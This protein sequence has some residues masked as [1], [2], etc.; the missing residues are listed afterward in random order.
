MK[1]RILTFAVLAA[2]SVS[3]TG[4]GD[5]K[6]DEP[7][8]NPNPN[9][10]TEV[11]T[12]GEPGNTVDFN[13]PDQAGASIKGVVYCGDKALSGVVVSD[14]VEVVTTD[15]NG[16]YYIN[17]A[18]KNGNVFVSIPSGYFVKTDG[19][20]PKFYGTLTKDASTVEQVNFELVENDKTDYVVIGL[21]DIH[22][23]GY[24]NNNEKY[25]ASVL[26][27][28]QATVNEYKAAGKDVYCITLGDESHDLYWYD[29]KLAIADTKPYF[30]R[31]G[32]TAMFHSMGNHDNDP[33]VGNDFGAE[34][35]FRATYGP[36]YYSFN[37]AGAH[38]VVLDNIVYKN[39]GASQGSMANR[40]YDNCVTEEQ[41]AWLRNDLAHV[42]KSTPVTVCMHAPFFKRALLSGN[43][44]VPTVAYHGSFQNPTALESCLSGYHVTMLTGHAHVNSSSRKGYITEY[45]IGSGAGC[46]WT[47]DYLASNHIGRDGS[48]GGYFVMERSGSAYKAYYKSVGFDRSYQM[49]TYDLNRCH[50]TAAKYCPASNDMLIQSTIGS[51]YLDGYDSERNDNKVQINVFGFNDRW[52]IKVTENGK[53]LAVKRINGYDPLWTI[54]TAC[55]ML[56]N[57]STPGSSHVPVSSSHFFEC[58]ASSASSTLRIEVKDE[59]GQTYVEEMQRPKDLA[60]DMR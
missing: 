31:T 4:C 48:V 27:D 44:Q 8:P 21:A 17:S 29:Y 20:W 18:K 47:S 37:I 55:K 19:V 15:E 40:D 60:V 42:P 58:Q 12:P 51:P 26:P 54:S 16:R 56:Q 14:G 33:Y 53:T 59:F 52:S 39:A 9:P 5:D 2:L 11:P 10:G 32:V 25:D 28:I 7:A 30:E 41:L 3:L 50:I 1:I 22:I 49:R 57:R 34:N 45:N 6:A 23:S 24:H 13:V 43:A 36:T 46:L 38:Y 35:Q